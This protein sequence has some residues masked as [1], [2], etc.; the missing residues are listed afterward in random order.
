M[1]TLPKDWERVSHEFHLHVGY[2][3]A[4][5]SRVDDDL[6]TIFRQCVGPHEQSAII[7]YRTPGLDV[8]FGLTNEL[9]LSLLPDKALQPGGHDHPDA[10]AWKKAILG[11]DKLLGERRRIAHH[12]VDIML[13]FPSRP[14]LINSTPFDPSAYEPRVNYQI[15]ASHHERLR[16]KEA[17]ARPLKL[18]DLG[19]HIQNVRGLSGRLQ[20]F[21]HATMKNYVPAF[22]PPVPQP[23]I[24]VYQTKDAST[25]PQPPP[26]SAPG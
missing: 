25:A 15:Y 5:W 12:P 16:R 7:Y 2:C 3:I 14:G 24:P 19:K 4:E 1:V 20:T 26:G 21:F 6:F 18:P 10:L 22:P 17:S 8:R 9:V 11:Y 23:P 13:D